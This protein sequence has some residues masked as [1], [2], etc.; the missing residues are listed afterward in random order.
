MNIPSKKI[1]GFSLLEVIIAMIIISILVLS[2]YSFKSNA[3]DKLEHRYE[4]ISELKTIDEL[5]RYLEIQINK[6]DSFIVVE[7]INNWKNNYKLK[8]SKYVFF[9]NDISSRNNGLYTFY[10]DGR[11]LAY[12]AS[13][14]VI[15][16]DSSIFDP[17]SIFAR[18]FG[19]NN[20]IITGLKEFLIELKDGYF[21]IKIE[22]NN[23]NKRDFCVLVEVLKYEK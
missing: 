8:K 10:K 2:L 14:N 17:E 16:P 21:E 7:E 4:K 20:T 11:R 6:A 23:G 3:I 13:R 12:L 19:G 1:K 5:A 22:D 15:K 9:Y 18:S